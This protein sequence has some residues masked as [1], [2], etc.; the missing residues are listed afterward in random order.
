MSIARLTGQLASGGQRD[1]KGRTIINY[2]L[3]GQ[4]PILNCLNNYHPDF[5]LCG[6][7]LIILDFTGRMIIKKQIRKTGQ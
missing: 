7:L 1:F 6:K 4:M 3:S 5:E 2:K